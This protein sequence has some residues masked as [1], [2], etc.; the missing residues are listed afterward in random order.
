MGLASACG[1]FPARLA[2]AFDGFGTVWRS[3]QQV[4][5]TR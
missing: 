2:P 5:A 3:G 4:L 1:R